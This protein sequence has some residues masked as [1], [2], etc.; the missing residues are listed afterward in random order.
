MAMPTSAGS[1]ERHRDRGEEVGVEPGGGQ[2]PDGFL[3]AVGR[4]GA[5]H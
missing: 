4:V 1:Q 3:H 2:A 5:D